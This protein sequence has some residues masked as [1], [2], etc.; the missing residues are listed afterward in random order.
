[1]LSWL[2][3]RFRFRAALALAA[4]YA[5]CVLAPHAALAFADATA[6]AHCLNEGRGHVHQP[7][8]VV[9]HVH[10]DGATHEH[11][12]APGDAA[13][14]DGKSLSTNCCGLFC[15]TGLANAMPPLLAAPRLARQ[16]EP[17]AN[18]GLRSRGPDR[19]N[20]PPIA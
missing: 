8:A 5:L 19:I 20:R 17:S 1:M 16:V 9:A 2:A 15:L 11:G 6:A 12:S 10:A 14:F 18:Q 7:D 3:K 13:N 4:L